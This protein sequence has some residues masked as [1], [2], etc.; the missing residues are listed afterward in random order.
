MKFELSPKGVH[1]SD[2][3]LLNDLRRVA[4]IVGRDHVLRSDYEAHGKF[5]RKTI[6]VRFGSWRAAHE[7]AGLNHT[8]R[9]AVTADQ[10]IADLKRVATELGRKSVSIADY[11]K[12]GRWSERPFYDTFDNWTNALKA[13][14]LNRHPLAHRRIS[15][16]EYFSNIEEMWRKLGRQPRYS[17]VE[18]PFS[19][20]SS[21]AYENRFGSWRKA[22][23]A[24]IDYVERPEN[25]VERVDPD[26]V[27]Q[28]SAASNARP[29]TGF[30]SS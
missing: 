18:K 30:C 21:G 22:L 12:V 24:F 11:R 25:H 17:E 9:D 27:P 19:R 20:Y 28:T 2:S 13:A 1:Y 7:A 6:S 3:E 26:P 23:E 8:A 29:S 5:N 15:N 10:L 4:R 14:G 16:M